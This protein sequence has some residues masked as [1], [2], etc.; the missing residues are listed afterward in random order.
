[1]MEINLSTRTESVLV[2]CLPSFGLKTH[3]NVAICSMA[4]TTRI[5]VTL[6]IHFQRPPVRGQSLALENVLIFLVFLEI[7]P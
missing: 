4:S 2:C 1:M 5:N 3:W 7:E 6:R